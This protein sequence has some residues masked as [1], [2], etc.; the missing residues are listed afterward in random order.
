MTRKQL[1]LKSKDDDKSDSNIS[2]SHETASLTDRRTKARR[3]NRALCGNYEVGYCRPPKK[4][5]F[6][7][8]QSGNP[9]GR[10][11]GRQNFKTIFTRVMSE[12]ITVTEEDKSR[13]LSK[14]EAMV[15]KHFWQAIEGDTR[16][17][18]FLIA[19]GTKTGVVAE[20]DDDNIHSDQ[21]DGTVDKPGN[22]LFKNIDESLLS[23]KDLIDLSRASQILDLGGDF[24][25]LSTA[26]FERTKEIVNKGRGKDITPN[27][28]GTL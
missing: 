28:V 7:P 6:K 9:R 13:T 20:I 12:R 19:L 3:D 17:A 26:D 8:G 10:P 16:S 2:V 25:A 14:A 1:A 21:Y 22:I 27:N 11:A 4:T 23:P 18:N 5:Q 24:T 15:Q